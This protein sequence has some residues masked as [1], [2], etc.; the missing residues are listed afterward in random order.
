ME[1]Q[2]SEDERTLWVGSVDNR[3]TEEILWELFLQAGP[4]ESVKI[5]KDFKTG[6]KRNFAFIKFQH[7]ESVPYVI[8]LMNGIILYDSALKLCVKN[9]PSGNGNNDTE[10]NEFEDAPKRRRMNPSYEPEQYQQMQYIEQQ[11]QFGQ[12]HGQGYMGHHPM[13]FH[14][15]MI[16]QYPLH[17]MPHQM[18]PRHGGPPH[19]M[20]RDGSPFR[21]PHGHEINSDD[22]SSPNMQKRESMSMRRS[23]SSP[24]RMYDEE[25]Q[26]D[27]RRE[28]RYD[29]SRR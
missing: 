12:F 5:P 28:S 7:K 27:R 3:V 29:R 4:L 20:P 16:T 11:Q 13:M 17:A 15:H 18:W 25:R 10:Q 2:A 26:V 1:K 23:Y 19:R 14:P 24:N 6:R 22:R 8:E 21:P 9:K